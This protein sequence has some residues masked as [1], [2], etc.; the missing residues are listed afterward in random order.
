[1]SRIFYV[2]KELS[3]RPKRSEVERPAVSST[4]AIPDIRPM[5]LDRLRQ[6]RRALP[7]GFSFDRE[8]VHEREFLR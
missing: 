2:L 4:L 1:M 3:S 5:A 7:S 6:L 8:T